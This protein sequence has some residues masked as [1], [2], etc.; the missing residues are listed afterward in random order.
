MRFPISAKLGVG[1][2]LVLLLMLIP[3]YFGFEGM[4]AL[5]RAYVDGVLPATYG[6]QAN[7]QV[8]KHVMAQALYVSNYFLTGDASFQV[9]FDDARR[10][11][12]ETLAAWRLQISSGE[13]MA[14]LERLADAQARVLHGQ[15][16]TRGCPANYAGDR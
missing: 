12:D 1:F 15:C 16:R 4:D 6:L 3:P 13:G 5:E 7:E 2:G 8:E 14:N 10:T 9:Q 11:V